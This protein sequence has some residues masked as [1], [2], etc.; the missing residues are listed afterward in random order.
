MPSRVSVLSGKG[1]AAR[2]SPT[3]AQAGRSAARA[4][5]AGGSIAELQR[6]LGN[7]AFGQAVRTG[8]LPPSALAGLGGTTG[9]QAVQRLARQVGAGGAPTA[10]ATAAGQRGA[11]GKRSGLVAQPGGAARPPS[12][13]SIP[14]AEASDSIQRLPTQLENS[15]DTLFGGTQVGVKMH[16]GTQA[17]RAA[18]AANTDAVAIGGDIFFREGTYRPGTAEGNAVIAREST[19]VQRSKMIGSTSSTPSTRASSAEKQ[20]AEQVGGLF[21]VMGANPAQTLQ[22]MRVHPTAT[23]QRV[24]Q[25]AGEYSHTRTAGIVTSKVVQGI[26]TTV[27]GP[28]GLVWRGPL[29]QKNLSEITGWAQFG[30]RSGKTDGKGKVVDR[31]RYGNSHL[32]TAMRWMAGISELLKE[33]TIW[34]GFGTFIAAIVAAATHGA[35]APVFA[36]LALAT[37]VVAGVHFALRS[38]L[39]AMNGYRLW[40]AYKRGDEKD[41]AKIPFIKHQMVSDG[42]EGIGAAIS[43]VLSG[44]NAGGL[45]SLGGDLAKDVGVEGS[46]K[47][48]AGAGFGALTGL[49]T[50]IGLATAKE[51]GKDAVKPGSEKGFLGGFLKDKG[52]IDTAYSKDSRSKFGFKS[53]AKPPSVAQPD[54]GGDKGK[55]LEMTTSALSKSAENTKQQGVELGASKKNSGVVNATG[56][57]VS[58]TAGKVGEAKTELHK[59]GAQAKDLDE[60]LPALVEQ[61]VGGSEDRV[62]SLSKEVKEALKKPEPDASPSSG[63]ADAVSQIDKMNVELKKESEQTAVTGSAVVGRSVQRK[64]GSGRSAANWIANKLGGLKAGVRRLNAKIVAGVLKY[65]AKLDKSEADRNS[66]ILAM[67]EEKTFAN[68]DVQEESENDKLFMAFQDKAAQLNTNVRALAEKDK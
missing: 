62:K 10:E 2:Q 19:H 39:V 16:T 23:Q 66:T 24:I 36:G 5:V 32:G 20:D 28:I 38:L 56:S 4:T 42:L 9:N 21:R 44:M 31:Q 45:G 65:A 8:H 57:A 26:F 17:D 29:I 33:F 53:K 22:P 1:A 63:D 43:S 30:G 34:L 40:A 52:D 18:R 54:P 58:D 47:S 37:S 13:L 35:F 51:G 55:A 61:S 49:P 64:G 67:S 11:A 59:T 6:S 15:M 7:H 25:R 60:K 27:L 12:A 68:Q 50:S 46:S 3:L 48:L 14:K 41:K